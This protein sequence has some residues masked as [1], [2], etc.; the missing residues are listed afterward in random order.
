MPLARALSVTVTYWITIC[1]L[2]ATVL[3]SWITALFAAPAV[4]MMS[5]LVRTCV[6]LMMTL[7]RRCPTAVQ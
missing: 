4:A 3:N 2:L 1:P 6:P 5:K 7:N